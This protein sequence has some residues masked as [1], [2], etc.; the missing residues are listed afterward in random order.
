MQLVLPLASGRVTIEEMLDH[1]AGELMFAEKY[2]TG[3][4]LFQERGLFFAVR[5][6]DRL[7]ARVDRVRDLDHAANFQRVRGGDHEHTGALDMRLNE[8]RGIGSVA[9]NRRDIAPAQLLDDLAIFFGHH[10]RD[11]VGGQRL[12]NAP[13]DAYEIT[14]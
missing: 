13:T 5:A 3:I 10:E 4:F 9:R 7:D 12:A 14:Q 2:L 11:A 1:A 8:N 6:H